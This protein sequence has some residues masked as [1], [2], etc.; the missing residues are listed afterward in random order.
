MRLRQQSGFGQIRHHV[1]NGCRAQSFAVAP[2]QRARANRFTGRDVGLDDGRQNFLLTSADGRH[3]IYL[4]APPAI[5]PGADH[6][7]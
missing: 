3:C 1:S 2:C 4:T 7:I 5:P 6:L